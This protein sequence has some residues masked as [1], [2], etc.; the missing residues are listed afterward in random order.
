MNTQQGKMLR[1]YKR[2]SVWIGGW[3]S[4]V[5]RKGVNTMG[6]DEEGCWEEYPA[7]GKGVL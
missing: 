5:G 1:R 7:V 3:G 2:E 6:S 4:G